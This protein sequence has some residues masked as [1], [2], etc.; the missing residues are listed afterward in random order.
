MRQQIGRRL[1]WP[2]GTV[3]GFVAVTGMA[4]PATQWKPE[5]PVTLVVPYAAGGGTDATARAVSRQLGAIWGQPVV[6]ENLPGADGLIGTRKVMEARPDGYTLLLQVPAITITSHLPGLKGIDPLA[7]LQPIT[8]I[9]QS[10]AAIVAS[11]KLPVSTLAE[12]VRYCKAAAQ[13]CSLG[14]GE[15]LARV[16]G[17][18]LAAEAGIS[19]LIVVNY[20]GTGPIV[21]DLIANNVNMSFTGITAALPHY[22][23]GTLKILATQGRTRAAAL[24]DVP[25]TAEAGFPQ[26]QSVTWFGLFAPKGTPIAIAEELVAALR[27]GIKDPEVRRTIAAAGAEPVVS[28]PAEFAAQVKH[29]R[30]RLDELIRKYPLE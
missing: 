1:A 23:A 9:S 10:P 14:S 26:F 5:R 27:E 29:D 8:A 3:L 6:V 28:S 16:S 30:D 21:T 17:K 2:V 7:K 12:L 18:Q 15:S 4:G 19:N 24:P 13:P 22:K 11:A 20:R 25:T